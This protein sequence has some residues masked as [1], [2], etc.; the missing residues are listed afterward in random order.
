MGITSFAHGATG[1]T[2]CHRSFGIH[3]HASPGSISYQYPTTTG[4]IETIEGTAPAFTSVV[5][6]V[7]QSFISNPEVTVT[8][9]TFNA[10]GVDAG[11]WYNG[12]AYLLLVAN[13]NSSESS[14][15]LLP[16]YVPW[17]DVGLG[18][19]T[20][21]DTSQIQRIFTNL[22]TTNV[23]GLKFK[24]YGIGIYTVTPPE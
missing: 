8:H 12:T 13:L 18:M 6:R 9:Q 11:L 4:N 1:V 17:A 3:A 10:G 5:A 23:T 24:T 7:I 2:N 15:A 21:N 20:S 22:Q 19:V 16:A 14:G